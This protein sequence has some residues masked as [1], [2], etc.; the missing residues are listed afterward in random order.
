MPIT[1]DQ[2]LLKQ[3]NRMALVRAIQRQPS[4][5][6]ADLAKA[7]GLT[8]STVSLLVQ[9]L[10]DEGW[11][12][13]SEAQTTGALGRRPTPLHLDQ[14]RSVLLGAEIGVEFISVVAVSLGGDLLDSCSEAIRKPVES[15][16]MRDLVRLLTETV[17]KMKSEGRN[18]LGIGVGVPG[19]VD[20]TRGVLKVA[21]NLGWRDV[22][23]REQLQAA[24]AKAGAANIPIFIQN[25][26]D[27]AALG[28]FE[29]GVQPTPEP[30]IYLSLGVGVGAGIIANDR[31]FMGA[32]GF[33]GEVGHSILQV[34]GPRCSCGRRGCA[35]AFLGLRS[36]VARAL[37]DQKQLHPSKVKA[38]AEKGEN[39]PSEALQS[40]GH[41]LGILLQN[42][43]T[44]FNPGRIVLGGPTCELGPVF[45][46]AALTSLG[47]YADAA[48]LPPPEVQLSAFGQDA[49]A[50]GAA[51]LVLHRLLRPLDAPSTY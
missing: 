9:E 49:V 34:D 6:R 20:E 13:E 33:A 32:D 39:R 10:I 5:S 47:S 24:L 23:V 12:A 14:E 17:N 42:L 35:E 31:L 19:A 1:G 4:M 7:T 25:E 29:F 3:I 41:Q 21:P 38:L 48:E 45:L 50:I 51:A 16:V 8:K 44:A 22:S 30:L 27:V 18:M 37:P 28:E 2:S 11:L 46:D 26:A 36:I 40:A 15:E 43:W